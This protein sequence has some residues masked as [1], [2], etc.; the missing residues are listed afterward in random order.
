LTY[1]KILEPLWKKLT[2]TILLFTYFGA[3]PNPD[4]P[5]KIQSALVWL[6]Q[7]SALANFSQADFSNI[8][9]TI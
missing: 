5:A 9:D 8:S 2:I 4:Q 1:T 7:I 3:D 6:R